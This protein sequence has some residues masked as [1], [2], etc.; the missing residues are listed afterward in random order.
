MLNQYNVGL[1]ALQEARWPGQGSCHKHGHTL[2]YSGDSRGQHILGTAFIVNDKLLC[3]VLNFY[4]VN[5]RLCVLRIKG[6]F[7]NISIVNCHAPTEESTD[8]SKDQFYDELE[9]AFGAI[10]AYD[11]K[12]VIG[13]FNAKLGREEAWRPHLGRESL[14]EECNE[15]GTRLASFAVA[16][17]LFAKST[18]FPHRDVHKQTWRSP[19]GRTYNKIDHVLINRRHQSSVYNMRSYRGDHFLVVLKMRHKLAVQSGP[20]PNRPPAW[21][22]ER[23]ESNE[24][25][26]SFQLELTNRF[27]SL[28]SPGD[29]DDQWKE[30]K[31]VLCSAADA[32]LGKRR[33]RK[34]SWFNEQCEQAVN[35]RKEALQLFLANPQ[36]KRRYEVTRRQ[37]N[38]ILRREKRRFLNE[39][40]ASIEANRIANN[41]RAMYRTIKSM[42]ATNIQGTTMRDANG[43]LLTNPKDALQQWKVYFDELLNVTSSASADSQPVFVAVQ[44]EVNPPSRAEVAEAIKMLKNHKSPGNDFIPAELLK[45]GGDSLVDQLYH[46]ISNI[47]NREKMPEDWKEALIIPVFKKGDRATFGNYRGISLLPSCYKVLSNIILKRIQPYAEECLGDYQAGFR[48]NRSTTDQIFTLRQIFEKCWEHNMD[49]HNIFVDFSKAYDSIIRKQMWSILEEFG[50]PHKIISMAKVCVDGSRARVKAE[51]GLSEAFEVITGVKQGDSLSP[52]LFNLVLEKAVRKAMLTPGGIQMG[53]TVKLLGY[54]DDLDAMG[55]EQEEVEATVAALE[56]EALKVGLKINVGKT[57]YLHLTRTTTTQR[58]ASR[59]EEVKEFRYLGSVVTSENQIK[60]DVKSRIKSANVAFF[61]VRPLFV[62]RLLS[63]TTKVRLYK[64]LVR[65]VLLYGAEAWTLTV[66]DTNALRVFENKMLRRIFGGVWQDGRWRM[67]TN[68]EIHSLYGSPNVVDELAGRRLQWLGHL[69]RMEESRTARQVWQATPASP[70]PPGRPRR[71]WTDQTMLDVRAA[72]LTPRTWKDAAADR[73]R[74]RAVVV[75]A[76]SPSGLTAPN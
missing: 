31:E 9:T 75:A 30:I 42:R 52:C 20:S 59:F 58:S 35:K 54:A 14:H 69:H 51:G 2:F 48:R 53:T 68:A 10:P 24:G 37:T 72:G 44:P 5:S 56:E 39:K 45:K 18:M 76:K 63:R 21:N 8:V 64:T 43:N 6:R 26:Q 25:A 41:G 1:C 32:T 50:I 55:S 47:W 4:P 46:L 60:E 36:Y 13:D 22:L 28:A 65:P 19:D 3:N 73:A 70:R 40:V 17:N 11:V 57:K 29:I 62:T 23:L 27:A 74:W 34:R 16:N 33:R 66:R 49:V 61:Q 7:Q 38:T 15:N 67:R 12:L 71:R